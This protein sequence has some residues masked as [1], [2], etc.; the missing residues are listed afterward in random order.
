M[1]NIKAMMR[2]SKRKQAFTEN[3]EMLRTGKAKAAEHGL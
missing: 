1:N 2:K 3:P